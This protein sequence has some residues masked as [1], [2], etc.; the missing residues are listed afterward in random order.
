MSQDVAK[1]PGRIRWILY[2][3]LGLIALA[4]VPAAFL[5]IVWRETDLD[6]KPFTVS[7]NK[8]EPVEGSKHP[9]ANVLSGRSIPEDVVPRKEIDQIVTITLQN[10]TTRPCKIHL[11]Y[12]DEWKGAE[13]DEELVVPA[14]SKYPITRNLSLDDF[15]EPLLELRA[16]FDM[17]RQKLFIRA[18]VRPTPWQFLMQQLPAALGVL[19]PLLSGALF[20]ALFFWRRGG[21]VLPDNSQVSKQPPDRV[22][23]R[24]T[25]AT[26]LILSTSCSNTRTTQRSQPTPARMRSSCR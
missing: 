21:I 9:C 20:I 6:T 24:D 1:K 10:E 17:I 4:F 12:P 23:Q 7:S 8:Y 3:G 14:Q 18:I 11:F 15:G 16:T 5:V 25:E 2:G 22:L 19:I 13:T 26:P